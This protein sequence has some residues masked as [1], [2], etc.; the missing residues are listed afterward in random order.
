MISKARHDG[1]CR[2]MGY[3]TRKGIPKIL[4]YGIELCTCTVCFASAG[5]TEACVELAI[6]LGGIENLESRALGGVF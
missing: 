4:S 1:K 2:V 6:R 5:G 3:I